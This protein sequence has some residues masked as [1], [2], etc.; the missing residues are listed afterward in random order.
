[1][2]GD[3]RAVSTARRWEI[4]LACAGGILV[5]AA[6]ALA[7]LVAVPPTVANLTSEVSDGA[8]PTELGE[9]SVVVPADWVITRESEDAVT[10]RT[11]DG[12]L[13]ANLESVDEKPDEV[14]ADLAAA[15][16]VP[17]SELLASGLT[18]VHVDLRDG[19]VVA[20]VGAPDA[21]SSV[22]VVVEVRPPEGGAVQAYRTAISDLLE[23]IR[24]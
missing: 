12:A 4:A 10:V 23:G 24:R 3:S 6:I 19:G 1:M 13:R 22:R 5:L 2:S 17:R 9:A 20:G 14:V 11:P 15:G 16:A 8:A 18:V 7:A 21:A